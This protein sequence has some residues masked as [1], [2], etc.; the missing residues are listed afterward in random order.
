MDEYNGKAATLGVMG[1]LPNSE[2][3]NRFTPAAT[4]ASMRMV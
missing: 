4:A 3:M 2:G 1:T